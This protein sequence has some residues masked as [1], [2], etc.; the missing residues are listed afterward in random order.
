MYKVMSS[1]SNNAEMFILFCRN[2]MHMAKW[3][4]A[5][6]YTFNESKVIME[7]NESSIV[8]A[9]DSF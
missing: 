1:Y 9:E 5:E 3:T 4:P 7:S 6:I 2:S 8:N